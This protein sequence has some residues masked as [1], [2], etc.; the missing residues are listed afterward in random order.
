MKLLT[1][2]TDWKP[3]WEDPLCHDREVITR[4]LGMVF[5]SFG[6]LANHSELFPPFLGMAHDL[7]YMKCVDELLAIVPHGLCG[8][9]VQQMAWLFLCQGWVVPEISA[10][11]LKHWHMSISCGTHLGFYWKSEHLWEL[12]ALGLRSCCSEIPS[13]LSPLLTKSLGILPFPLWWPPI[14]ELNPS[15]GFS[16]PYFVSPSVILA[17]KHTMMLMPLWDT[18]GLTL[19]K[20]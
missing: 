14:L 17:L 20:D 1:T 16:S 13:C 9:S 2:F 3:C 11:V 7:H 8:V 18:G 4:H 10:K 6:L 5:T 19:E 12:Q 15:W